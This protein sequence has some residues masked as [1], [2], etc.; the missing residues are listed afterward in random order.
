M[1][2]KQTASAGTSKEQERLTKFFSHGISAIFNAVFVLII[3]FFLVEKKKRSL[4]EFDVVFASGGSPVRKE[5]IM[6]HNL[7]GCRVEV[8]SGT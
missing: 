2:A 6:P 1:S 5:T 7:S 8:D 3:Y 4:E